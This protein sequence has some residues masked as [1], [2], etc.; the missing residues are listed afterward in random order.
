MKYAKIDRNTVFHKEISMY[1]YVWVVF[2]FTTTEKSNKNS[3]KNVCFPFRMLAK[4][5]VILNFLLEFL[6]SLWDYPFCFS[7]LQFFP[8]PQKL[9]KLS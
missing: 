8:K 7:D 2:K 9:S 5:F 6:L 4:Q 1:L 3:N